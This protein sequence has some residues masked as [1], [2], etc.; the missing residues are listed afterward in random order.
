MRTIPAIS[1]VVLTDGFEAIRRLTDHLRAQTRARDLELVILCPERRVLELPDALAAEL[2][3]VVVVE[4]PMLPVGAAR[5]AA[6]GAASSPLVALGETHAFPDSEWA[7]RVIAAHQGPCSSVAPGM[8]NGNP[9]GALSWSGFLMDYGR[10]L[11]TMPGGEIAEGPAYNAIHKR[12]ALLAYGD[13]LADLLEPGGAA[14]SSLGAGGPCRHE[15]GARVA[16]LNVARPLHWAAERYWG[17]R[18]FGAHRARRWRLGRRLMFF[19]A[20]PVVPVLRFAR[21][22]PALRRAGKGSG[23]PRGTIFALAVGSICWGI[24][25]A[26]GYLAGEGVSEQRMW[27]YELHK[28]RYA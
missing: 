20:S 16:H 21:T 11:A 19:A 28:E 22:L 14:D 9:S 7:E 8:T 6:I 12:D 25:E 15:P 3:A 13:R 26:I 5:A 17:G 4:H 1:M 27:E 18:L 23:V 24:G 2:G 10:W